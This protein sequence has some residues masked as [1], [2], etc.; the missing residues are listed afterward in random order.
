MG[1]LSIVVAVWIVAIIRI[2]IMKKIQP[3]DKMYPV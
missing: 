3:D 1:N 2:C